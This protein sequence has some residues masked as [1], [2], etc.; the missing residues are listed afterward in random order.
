MTT[1]Q[2]RPRRPETVV[3]TEI[4][5]R[6]AAPS[7]RRRP[8]QYFA[9]NGVALVMIVAL[10]LT[11]ICILYLMQTAK[12]AGLGYKF[13][14]LQDSYYS[15][16]LN[17]SKLGY[18]VAREQSLDTISQIATSQLGM[19][20]IQNFDFLQVQRPAT[21]NLPALPPETTSHPT[22]W[23]RIKAAVT[24]EASASVSQRPSPVQP[25]NGPGTP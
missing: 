2:T 25:V 23:D 21:D 18:D 24:G 15:L 3:V 13:S 14:A 17:N 16:S 1:T 11:V 4:S 5:E 8:K 7:G 20:P 12:V 6:T 19:T 22:L 9:L 10:A